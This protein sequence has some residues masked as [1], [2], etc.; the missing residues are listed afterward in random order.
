M[1]LSVAWPSNW[2]YISIYSPVLARL[3]DV[4]W[5][6]GCALVGCPGWSGTIDGLNGL[7]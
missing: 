6:G 1:N 2:P 3:E 4:K 5:Y 7:K